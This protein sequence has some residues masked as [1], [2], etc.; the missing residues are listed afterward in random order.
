[1]QDLRKL[2]A[3]DEPFLTENGITGHFKSAY[4][5]AFIADPGIAP[6]SV[7]RRGRA[8]AKKAAAF[9]RMADARISST[10][11]HAFAIL[12][13]RVLAFCRQ[14]KQKQQSQSVPNR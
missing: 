12:L 4:V 8:C 9:S 14:L 2:F 5:L 1:M 10:A 7:L 11:V 13:R 6:P 3:Q